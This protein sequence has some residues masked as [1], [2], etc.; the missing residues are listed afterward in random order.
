[1]DLET[2]PLLQNTLAKYVQS[3]LPLVQDSI[4]R[5][6][7]E[8]DINGQNKGQNA[9]QAY[10]GICYAYLE[11]TAIRIAPKKHIED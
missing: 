9:V 2:I 8:W 3:L 1:M 7:G 10:S 4:L 6:Y 11:T 5:L